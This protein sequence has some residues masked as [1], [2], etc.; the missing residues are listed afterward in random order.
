ML[1]CSVTSVA[2]HALLVSSQSAPFLQARATPDLRHTYLLPVNMSASEFKEG[3]SVEDVCEA[4]RDVDKLV[5][6]A[7]AAEVRSRCVPPGWCLL[8]L[9]CQR[10]R[11][12]RNV[13]ALVLFLPR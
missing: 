1:R 9:P 11:G 10:L 3:R 2:P 6:F 7:K 8:H 4:M 13:V 12:V 5:Q